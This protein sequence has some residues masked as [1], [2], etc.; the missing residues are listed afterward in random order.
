MSGIKLFESA[1]VRR[2]RVRIDGK[3]GTSCPRLEL[4]ESVGNSL[5]PVEAN[6]P[7]TA[8]NALMSSEAVA[9]KRLKTKE[10]RVQQDDRE[11]HK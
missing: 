10:G 6:E 5:L 2:T 11:M 9:R 4:L 8:C 7:V 1:R 3:W